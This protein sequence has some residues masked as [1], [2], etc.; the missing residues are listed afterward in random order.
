MTGTLFFVLIIAR[1][2]SL[3]SASGAQQHA[4]P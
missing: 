1:L 2:V 3:Y 4:N